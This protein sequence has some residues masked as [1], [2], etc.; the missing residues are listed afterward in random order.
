MGIIARFL[1][2]FR[3]RRTERDE[4]IKEEAAADVA[5]IEEDDKFFDPDAPANQDELL[6]QWPHPAAGQRMAPMS[7]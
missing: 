2:P 1:D 6:S 7:W 5:A 4:E 3:A